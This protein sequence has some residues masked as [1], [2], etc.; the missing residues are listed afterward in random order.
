VPL[1]AIVGSVFDSLTMRP[2]PGATVQMLRPD[3][4][5]LSVSSDSAGTFRFGDLASGRHLITFSH[6]KLDSLG[7]ELQA[8]AVDVNTDDTVQVRLATP[9]PRTIAR[10]LCPP[11]STHAGTGSLLGFVR[12]AADGAPLGMSTVWIRFD[13]YVVS[14]RRVQRDSMGL[15]AVTQGNGYF[16]ICG[17]PAEVTVLARAASGSDTSGYLELELKPNAYLKRDIFIGRLFRV[18]AAPD[19]AVPAAARVARTRPLLRGGGSLTGTIRQSDGRPVANARISIWGTGR[20]AL[21]G[22]GGTFL[23]DSLPTGSHMVDVRALG[24]VPQREPVDVQEG[25]PSRAVITMTAKQVFL[26]TV[27]VL[28]TSSYITGRIA[29]F[30]GRRR[31]RIGGYFLDQDEI[32]RRRAAS[33]TD[34]LRGIPTVTID[35]DPRHGDQVRMIGAS[36]ENDPYCDPAI[37]I[38][39]SRQPRRE[40]TLNAIL[41]PERIVALEVYSRTVEAPAQFQSG[42][43]CGVILVWTGERVRRQIAPERR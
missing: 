10:T 35:P 21:S 40:G 14:R 17:I 34:L 32:D 20:E 1:G 26:D 43:R 27:R 33:F 29:E 6:G 30:E 22:D 25:A 28:A 31:S 19:T 36:N 8:R 3:Q 12:S 16:V 9:S 13:D 41:F 42:S 15:T 7:I 11:D 18:A 37:W 39:G 38:D 4:T 2:L 24:F 23:L 5:P